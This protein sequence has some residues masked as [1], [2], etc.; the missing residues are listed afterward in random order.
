MCS[1]HYFE[2]GQ[3]EHTGKEIHLKLLILI[4]DACNSIWIWEMDKKLEAAQQPQY[5]FL[6]LVNLTFRSFV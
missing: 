5:M 1:S 2:F 4:E 6:Q 3:T